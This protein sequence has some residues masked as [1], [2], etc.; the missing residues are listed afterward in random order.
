MCSGIVDSLKEGYD[1]SKVAKYFY[2]EI[3]HPRAIEIANYEFFWNV[4]DEL[5]PFGTED[6]Y[7]A[8]EELCTWIREN[9]ETPIIK[10]FEWILECW[11]LNLND[12]NDSI[13]EEDNI[14]KLILD[15]DFDEDLMMLDT[16]IIVTGF[17]QLILQGKIDADTKNII[18]LSILRQM[19]SQVLDA[20]LGSNEQWKFERYKYLSK[21]L[22]ILEEA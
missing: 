6:A 21:L 16:A 22:D 19:N 13:L 20:F 18:Q 9:P 11:E 15:Y 3:P 4:R 8:F 7:I 1:Y 17:G 5:A 2:G 14:R 12:F 10:C